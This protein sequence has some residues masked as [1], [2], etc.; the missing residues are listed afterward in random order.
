MAQP[1]WLQKLYLQ[2]NGA[3]LNLLPQILHFAQLIVL[4]EI[5]PL[6]LRLEPLNFEL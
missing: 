6:K 1:Y 2:Q 5:R 3:L 4:L